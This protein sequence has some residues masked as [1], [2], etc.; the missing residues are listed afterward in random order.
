MNVGPAPEVDFRYQG[1][2]VPLKSPKPSQSSDQKRKEIMDRIDRLQR[3][4]RPNSFDDPAMI[5]EVGLILL[6]ATNKLARIGEAKPATCWQRVRRWL[7]R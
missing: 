4:L 7:R 1:A 3:H 6:E 2:H 5:A